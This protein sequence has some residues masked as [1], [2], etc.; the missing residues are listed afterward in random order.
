MNKLLLYILGIFIL[1]SVTIFHISCN[2]SK[3]KNNTKAKNLNIVKKKPVNAY[4]KFDECE[5]HK[6][7]MEILDIVIEI[8]NTFE[9]I[10]E[11]RKHN[12]SKKEI[13]ILAKS[14][15]LLM[16]TC[17]ENNFARMFEPSDCND[18][19]SLEKKKRRLHDLG[20]Q[21]DQGENIRL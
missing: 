8:R 11:L 14:W 17:F 13:K 2:N 10:D 6:E 7:A 4:V 3:K 18:L 12:E 1:I 20:V 9:S 21:I 16:K 15:Q 19:K 5:C